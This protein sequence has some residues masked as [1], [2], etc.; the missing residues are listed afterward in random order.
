MY[1]KQNTNDNDITIV[2]AKACYHPK[3][4]QLRREKLNMLG[5]STF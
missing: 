3:I 2:Q 1:K 4:K 5:E